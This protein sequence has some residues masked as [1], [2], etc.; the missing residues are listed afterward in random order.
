MKENVISKPKK[1][2]ILKLFRG[3]ISL[4]I[5]YWVFGVLIGNFF[6]RAINLIIENNYAE[7]SISESGLTMVQAFFYFT[8]GYS[9]FILIA[10]WRSA[11]NYTKNSFWASA[12]KVSVVLGLLLLSK[13]LLDT[14]NIRNDYLAGINLEIVVMKKSLPVMT[15]EATRF[16]DV[17]L[18][19]K[20][21]TYKYTL[22]DAVK[23]DIDE[24]YFIDHMRN[25]I[26]E[27]CAD[28]DKGF[29]EFGGSY[30]FSYYDMNEILIGDI[31]LN[32]NDCYLY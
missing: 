8:I 2:F 12:A 3:D 17:Y 30:S 5:T 13:T 22:I 31:T 32:K 23:E 16:D 9:V 10:T 20:E 1:N 21:I 24:K 7:I 11:T 29:L 6:F 28:L 25:I 15:D 18:N 27:S 14:Y 26:L 4:P 19:E